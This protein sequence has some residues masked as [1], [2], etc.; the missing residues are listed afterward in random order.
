MAGSKMSFSYEGIGELL[1][2]DMLREHM[3]ARAKRIKAL[4][5]SRAPVYSGAGPD[6]TRGSYKA[7][8]RVESTDHGGIKHDRAAATVV[9][10]DPTA[11][12]I[13]FG[14]RAHNGIPAMPARHILGSSMM[15]AT[16]D[17]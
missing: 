10:D 7:S 9:N 3:V 17:E 4:A 12:F 13:E 11:V 8:F 2:S 1:R 5:E 14:T 15:A 6:P 16:G